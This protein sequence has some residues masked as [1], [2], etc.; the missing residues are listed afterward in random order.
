MLRQQLTGDLN[1]N[2]GTLV[3]TAD[4]GQLP[5]LLGLAEELAL[6]PNMRTDGNILTG[7][8]LSAPIADQP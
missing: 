6:R 7:M 8:D 2:T 4:V 1:T 3:I 5:E